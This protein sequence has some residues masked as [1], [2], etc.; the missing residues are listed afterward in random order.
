MLAGITLIIK[1]V[2]L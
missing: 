2:Y 1:P